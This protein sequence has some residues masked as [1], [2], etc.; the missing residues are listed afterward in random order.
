[1]R[2]AF[3]RLRGRPF[4]AGLFHD[5]QYA[6]WLARDRT[7]FVKR[8]ALRREARA[9]PSRPLVSV[10]MPVY[11]IGE[12]WLRAAIHS[13]RNQVY[14]HWELCAVDDASPA[15]HVRPLLERLAREDSRVRLHFLDRNEGISGALR[16]ALAMARG[17]LV[18]L[19]DH[20]DALHPEALLD[21]VRRFTQEPAPDV[22]YT[23]HDFR[24]ADGRRHSPFFKPDW[25]PDLLLSMNYVTHLVVARADLV[26]SVG[27]YRPGYDGAEDHDLL[28]RLS[29]QTSRIAHVPR[30]L[31]SWGRAPLSTAK[32]PLVKPYAHEAGRRAVE[33]ALVRRGIAGEAL[34]SGPGAYRYRVRRRIN[35]EPLVSVVIAP[36]GDQEAFDRC[37][38]SLAGT[39]WRRH[40]L[41][42][43]EPVDADAGRARRLN[44]GVRSA[45]GEHVLLL[46]E[47]CAVT[48]LEW[49]TAL[50]EHS[51]RD[52]VGAA[53]AKRVSAD[54]RL[55]HVGLVL[56]LQGVAGRPFQGFPQDH[57][58]Y[59]GLAH[60]TRN[61]AAVDASCLMTRRDLFLEGGG[62]DEGLGGFEDV[63]YCLRLR[64]KGLWI[65]Y[66]P[67][68]ILTEHSRAGARAGSPQG[69]TCLQ[70]RWGDALLHDPFYN[71]N[72]SIE[73]GD[74]SLRVKRELP[75]GGF[76]HR[77]FRFRSRFRGAGIEIGALHDPMAVDPGQARVQYVDRLTPAEQVEHY[78]ELGDYTLVTPDVIAPAHE[79]G[80]FA[81]RSLDFVIA[82]QLLNQLED[83]IAALIEW[84]RV[85]APGGL[86][87]LTVADH[88]LTFDRERTVVTIDHLVADHRDGG[89][90]SRAAHYEEYSR[91]A[92]GTVGDAAKKDSEDLMVRGYAATFHAFTPGGVRDLLRH[93]GEAK[94]C[95]WQVVVSEE[96]SGGD[97]ELIL[98]LRRR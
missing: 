31:Y 6:L 33:D 48:D 5:R 47:T 44:E 21:I 14:D 26:R 73:R 72:L 37:V 53:G 75:D 42:V 91:A 52:E 1:M 81:D 11:D 69:V 79:I 19:L 70:E 43:T 55:R 90:A 29:E 32:A 28:L 36:E 98:L 20:D 94:G 30:P 12:E 50:L 76:R 18:G 40:E 65:V 34:E 86:L 15:T 24:E 56:G 87:F 8:L 13:V 17:E 77:R 74:F 68:A 54:G 95:E 93:M 62:F 83:P 16:H 7:S 27:G 4:R 66:T 71:K 97:D 25:S 23:D 10:L 61:V 35:G 92:R 67:H 80:A 51:Q 41:I 46:R 84:H 49:M 39:A 3:A 89:A 85:L 57:S 88:R 96:P 38:A 82:N 64:N 63:D 9:L 22:V 45:R 2:W 58:T 78:P 60:A 59:W